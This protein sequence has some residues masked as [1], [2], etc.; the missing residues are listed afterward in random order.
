MRRRLPLVLAVAALALSACGSVA[1]DPT[2][3]S[4][5]G[6]DPDAG[7]ITVFA[8]ASLKEAFTTLGRMYE[9]A[10]PGAKVTFN[11]G[12]SSTLAT[13]ITQEAP[14]DVFA[15]ASQSTMDTVTSAGAA[16]VATGLR[17]QHPRGRY[18]DQPHHAGDEP[19][20]PRPAGRQGRR[21]P[22]GRP[23][24]RRGADALRPQPPRA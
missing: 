8:A 11:F 4:V 19:R 24:R 6:S 16:T 10:H 21:L 12:A 20:R 15:A 5:A 1:P 9:A 23:V 2:T 7:A 14:A 17:R 13:Q 18:A 3:S 22:A